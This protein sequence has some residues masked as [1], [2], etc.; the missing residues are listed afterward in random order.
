MSRALVLAL[1]ALTACEGIDDSSKDDVLLPVVGADKADAAQRVQMKGAL[2]FDQAVNGT[3][4]HDL[5]FHGYTL[6]A[7]PGAVV[8]L[9]VTQRGSSRT[10][11]TTLFVFGPRGDAG[12]PDDALAIDDDSGWGKLSRLRHLSLSK[13]GQYL[14]VIG[15]ANG[16]GRGHYGFTAT[17]A[18]G[19]CQ[20]EPADACGDGLATALAGAAEGVLYPSESDYPLETLVIPGAGGTLDVATA[21]R[22]LRIPADAQVETRDFD[23]LLGHLTLDGMSD[24]EALDAGYDEYQVDLAHHFAQIRDLMKAHLKDLRVIR[25]GTIQIKVYLIGRTPCGELAGYST[26]SIET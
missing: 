17:C 8:D 4:A 1:L 15:T 2:Q 20:P 21:R 18:S 26:T 9:E 3:I 5:E 25:V 7:L 24:Q 14:V 16:R 22:L 6:D 12:F 13:G 10:L 23:E 19:A 11:D